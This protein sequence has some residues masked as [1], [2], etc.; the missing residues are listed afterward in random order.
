MVPLGEVKDWGEGGLC[1]LFQSPFRAGR[2]LRRC[3]HLVKFV[4]FIKISSKWITDL[5]VN[6]KTIQLLGDNTEQNLGDLRDGFSDTTHAQSM[7]E[8]TNELDF[9]KMKNFTLPN[10]LV[11]E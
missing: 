3:V 5:N 1:I 10:I 8:I 2:W 9:I 6:H 11:R 4:P 7:R